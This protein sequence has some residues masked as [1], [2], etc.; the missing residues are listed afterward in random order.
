MAQCARAPHIHYQL[1]VCSQLLL[2]AGA[3]LLL[4]TATAHLLNTPDVLQLNYWPSGA[5]WST[6]HAFD[7]YCIVAGSL[8][9]ACCALTFVHFLLLYKCRTHLLV[10][11]RS[12]AYAGM[13]PQM[14]ETLAR[15]STG[16]KLTV[17]EHMATRL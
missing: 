2:I 10:S 8:L 1:Q 6:S 4:A 13:N 14:T 3:S 12:H 11:M 7:F 16:P 5:P 17:V 9:V 15:I